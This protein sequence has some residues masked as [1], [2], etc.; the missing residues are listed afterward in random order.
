LSFLA[1]AVPDGG[2]F[3][4]SNLTSH[5]FSPT[6]SIDFWMLGLQVLGISSLMAGFNFI[7]TIINMRAPGMT[8][9]RMPL[10]VWMSFV[11]QFLVV[12]AFPATTVPRTLPMSDPFFGPLFSPPAGGADPPLW[13]HLFWIFGPPEFYTLTPPAMGIVSEVL[14]TFSRKP[15][16]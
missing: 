14:P 12:L 16:F 10:F 3:G 13:Q 7:V 4:Y 8:L 6:H 5:Q 9:M 11:V 1:G 15:L 2:W